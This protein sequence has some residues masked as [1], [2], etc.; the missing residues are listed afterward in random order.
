MT[1]Q[2]ARHCPSV[3]MQ[4]RGLRFFPSVV[5]LLNMEVV[6]GMGGRPASESLRSFVGFLLLGE[7][8]AEGPRRDTD[9]G[10]ELLGEVAGTCEAHLPPPLQVPFAGCSRR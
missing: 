6:S 8:L 5:L 10:T 9:E 3:M 1:V 4:A 2:C 7:A